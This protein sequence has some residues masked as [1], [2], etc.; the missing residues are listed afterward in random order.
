MHIKLAKQGEKRLEIRSK[1]PES[2]KNQTIPEF[3]LLSR[4][5]RFIW[6]IWLD[7]VSLEAFMSGWANA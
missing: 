6:I 5:M 3:S 1:M 4:I 7:F 2:S